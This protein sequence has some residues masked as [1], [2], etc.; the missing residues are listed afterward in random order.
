MKTSDRKKDATQWQNEVKRVAAGIR[1]RVLEHTIRNNGGYLSQACSSAEILATLYVKVMDLGNIDAPL[2]PKP[3]PGVPGPGN[4]HYF[5]G[6]SFNGPGKDRDRF[7]LSPAQYALVL[8]ATLI[9]T[10]RMAE[11][12]LLQFNKDGA[13]SRSVPSLASMESMTGRWAASAVLQARP[14]RANGMGKRAGSC[15][16]CPT[17]NSRSARPGKRFRPCPITCSTT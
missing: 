12:G 17:A 9:E 3:F 6:A 4:P 10:G 13:R 8:Y 5:T 14:W 7:F 1:R 11:E 2:V 16:S 15:C